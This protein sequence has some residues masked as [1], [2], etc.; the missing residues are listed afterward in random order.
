MNAY[1]LLADECLAIAK[2]YYPIRPK[3]H[4]TLAQQCIFF[5]GSTSLLAIYEV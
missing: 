1:G 2:T 4:E 3:L 5:E